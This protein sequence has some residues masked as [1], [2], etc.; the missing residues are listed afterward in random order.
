MEGFKAYPHLMYQL[1]YYCSG[2]CGILCM[3]SNR[4]TLEVFLDF[5]VYHMVHLAVFESTPL[6]AFH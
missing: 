2:C 4:K 5:V 1:R 6:S 3:M